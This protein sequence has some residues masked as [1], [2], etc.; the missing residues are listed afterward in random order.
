MPV[1]LVLR[2]VRQEDYDLEVNLGYSEGQPW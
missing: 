1:T 2:K